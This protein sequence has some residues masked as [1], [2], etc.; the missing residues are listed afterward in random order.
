MNPMTRRALVAGSSALVIALS[1]AGCSSSKAKPAPATSAPATS[2]VAAATTTTVAHTSS[3][4]DTS[5]TPTVAELAAHLLAP[6]DIGAGFAAGTWK[7]ETSPLPCTPKVPDP[8][9]TDPPVRIAGTVLQKSDGSLALQEEVHLYADEA[10]ANKVAGLLVKGLACPQET[11]TSGAKP[12]TFTITG[13][14]DLT[15]ELGVDDA[16][17]WELKSDQATIDLVVARHQ[18]GIAVFEFIGAPG[19][20]TSGLPSPVALARKGVDKLGG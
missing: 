18:N 15:S 13:P 12:T 14:Q 8:D 10:E 4:T 16:A 5:S 6:A 19:A 3:S 7:H 1:V 9:I 20:D 11:D 17:G 2:V